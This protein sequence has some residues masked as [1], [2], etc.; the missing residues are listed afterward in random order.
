MKS[1]DTKHTLGMQSSARTF[2]F[3]LRLYW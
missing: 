2:G 3:H 1:P